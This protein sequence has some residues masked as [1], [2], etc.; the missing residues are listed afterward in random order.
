MSVVVEA[1]GKF[2]LLDVL[3]PLLLLVLSAL[4]VQLALCLWKLRKR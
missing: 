1:V 2:Y 3:N 4:W